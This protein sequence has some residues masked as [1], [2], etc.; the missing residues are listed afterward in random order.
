VAD[1][2]VT[3]DAGTLVEGTVASVT[4][5]TGYQ[6]VGEDSLTCSGGV[7]N[8]DLPICAEEVYSITIT[9]VEAL[10]ECGMGEECWIYYTVVASDGEL[11]SQDD[12]EVCK[13]EDGQLDPCKKVEYKSSSDS[14]RRGVE[15]ESSTGGQYVC[16]TLDGTFQSEPIT[17]AVIE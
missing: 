11:V 5:D 17:F 1:G 16:R 10:V 9:P 6:R 7:W 12:L 4:C 8:T 15:G 3:F 14:Y 2:V 13:L